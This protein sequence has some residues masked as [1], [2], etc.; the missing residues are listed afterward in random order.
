MSCSFLL[1]K[2]DKAQASIYNCVYAL[3]YKEDLSLCILLGTTIAL[4]E[5]FQCDLLSYKLWA[6]ALLYSS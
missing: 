2:E 5:D 4:L 3:H 1:I 6:W